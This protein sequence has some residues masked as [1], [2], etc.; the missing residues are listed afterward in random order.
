MKAPDLRALLVDALEA[1]HVLALREGDLRQT[2]L[3]GARDIPLHELDIDSLAEM[4]ICMSLE[5]ATGVS[6]VPEQ[7]KGLG[8]INSILAELQRQLP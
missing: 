1:G 3:S 5:L 7:L 8:S 4:E 6:L 2:I